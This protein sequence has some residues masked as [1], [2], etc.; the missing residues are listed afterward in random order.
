MIGRNDPCFCGSKKKWKKCHYP[1]LPKNRNQEKLAQGYYSQYK[2]ILK[3]PEQIDKIRAACTLAAQILDKTCAKAKAGITT[4]ELDTFAK[5][6]HDEAGA[7]PAP[8][9]YGDPPFPNSICTSLNE[10]ICHGIPNDIPLKEGDILNIDVSCILNGFFGDC[11]KMV[12]IGAVTPDKRLVVDVS[13]ESLM[14]SI[15][16][17]K[18]GI[19]LSEIGNV[20]EDYA[21]SL[22]CSVV[23]Q[24]VGHGVG[25]AF[26]EPP[27]VPHNRNTLAI[28]LAPGMTFTIEPM[29]NA[30]VREA[31]IDPD[32]HWTARTKDGRPSAQWEH[33]ILITEEGHEILTLLTE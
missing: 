10:E 26:H 11:S 29:I 27:Q 28:P 19:L 32:N 33:T 23:N 20:I 25:L 21:T 2:I 12:V 22:G 3:T 18:P 30:G 4:L 17:L 1:E 8:L 6:L 13:Y 9:G 15:K 31:M 14:R 5:R 24:F 16:I 7:I